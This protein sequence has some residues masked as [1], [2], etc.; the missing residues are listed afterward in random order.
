MLIPL[1]L[2]YSGM[3]WHMQLSKHII[4]KLAYFDTKLQIKLLSSVL[5]Y[6]LYKYVC[7]CTHN[8]TH[9]YIHAQ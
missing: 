4:F 7:I 8:Y 6:T 9:T 3:L 2:Q 1:L 5:V